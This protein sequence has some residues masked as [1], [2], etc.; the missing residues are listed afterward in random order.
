MR[1]RL[2][3]EIIEIRK[4]KSACS[5][6]TLPQSDFSSEILLIEMMA[7]TAALLIGAETDFKEDVVLT[8]IQKASF[9]K[10]NIQGVLTVKAF[11]EEPRSDGAWVDTEIYEGEQKVASGALLLMNVGHILEEQ[12]E[13]ICFYEEV[14]K[15][16]Q[17]RSKVIED[18][19]DE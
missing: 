6:A 13:P 12:S 19:K 1:W 18:V 4:S 7:Q 16:F 2:L 17:V 15:H 5:K 10:E 11:C 8:K 9:F 3:D 14:M